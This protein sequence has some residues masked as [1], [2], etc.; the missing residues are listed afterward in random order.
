MD[1]LIY[2]RGVAPGNLNTNTTRAHYGLQTNLN[3]NTTRVTVCVTH[4]VNN[5]CHH[6]HSVAHR[7]VLSTTQ[8][9][10]THTCPH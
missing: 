3:T 2:E 9:G 4:S 10:G 8:L 6:L 7:V 1:T 5:V